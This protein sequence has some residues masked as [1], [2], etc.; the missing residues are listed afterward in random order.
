MKIYTQTGH[1]QLPFKTLVK[2][3]GLRLK[4]IIDSENKL[5]KTLKEMGKPFIARG[6]KNLIFKQYLKK[7]CWKQL[8]KRP[9]G[10]KQ[11]ET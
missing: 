9:K 3:Q 2:S 6:Y 8:A 1:I 10:G 11:V 5:I 7:N 4:R